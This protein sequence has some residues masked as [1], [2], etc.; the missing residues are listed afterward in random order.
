MD[1]SFDFSTTGRHDMTFIPMSAFGTGRMGRTSYGLVSLEPVPSDD[2]PFKG[3]TPKMG[4]LGF[5]P[6]MLCEYKDSSHNLPAA[7][8][9]V[10]FL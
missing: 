5:L 1:E 10:D 3:C 4:P 2:S 8:T 7:H 6:M 9:Q